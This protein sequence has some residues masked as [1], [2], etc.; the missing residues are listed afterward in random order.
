MGYNQ[1]KTSDFSAENELLR[2]LRVIIFC[3]EKKSVRRC[4][5]EEIWKE[6]MYFLKSVSHI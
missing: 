5:E 6:K 1:S 4:H 3:W 2:M